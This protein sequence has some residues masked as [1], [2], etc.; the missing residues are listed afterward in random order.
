MELEQ[1]GTLPFLDVLVKKS[2]DG[3]LAHMVYRKMTNTGLYLHVDS[4][5]H[6]AQTRTDLSTLTHHA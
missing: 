6:P 3:T 2:T 1:N 4:E 5:H